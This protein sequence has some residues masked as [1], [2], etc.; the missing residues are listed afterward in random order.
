MTNVTPC[1]WIFFCISNTKELINEGSPNIEFW[2]PQIL[3]L[4]WATWPLYLFANIAKC[5]IIVILIHLRP[6]IKF[7]RDI[8]LFTKL[9]PDCNLLKFV[10]I[11]FFSFFCTFALFDNLLSKCLKIVRFQLQLCENKMCF[12]VVTFLRENLDLW[13]IMHFGYGFSCELKLVPLTSLVSI[14]S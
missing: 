4:P 11:F 8:Y 3:I 6:L 7:Y 5:F 13:V 10:F 9:F 14:V 2:Q 1:K 12:V